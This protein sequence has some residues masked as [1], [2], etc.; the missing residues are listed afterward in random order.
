MRLF[1]PGVKA[2]VKANRQKDTKFTIK[3]DNPR[4]FDLKLFNEVVREDVVML[5]VK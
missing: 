1:G 2:E 5:D 4:K 3:L